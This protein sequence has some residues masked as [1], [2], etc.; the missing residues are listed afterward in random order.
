[1]NLIIT[2]AN[3]FIG[4]KYLSLYGTKFTN[5]YVIGRHFD[6]RIKVISNVTFLD[7]NLAKPLVLDITHKIDVFIHLAYDGT[8]LENNIIAIRNILDFIKKQA[9]ER[10]IF[11]SSYSVYDTTYE[12]FL[13]ENAPYSKINDPYSVV[14][15]NCEKIIC[16]FSE[17]IANINCIVL[18]PSN[19]YGLMGNWSMHAVKSISTSKLI[20]PKEG[21]CNPVYVDD[22]CQAIHSSL[23]FDLPKL[24]FQKFLISSEESCEWEKFYRS[25]SIYLSSFQKGEIEFTEDISN[26]EFNTSVPKNIIYHLLFTKIGFLLLKKL[27]PLIRKNKSIRIISTDLKKSYIE[28]KKLPPFKPSGMNRVAHR[29]KFKVDISKAKK[30]L[31]YSPKF[32]LSNLGDGFNTKKND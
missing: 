22:V 14:K 3:G 9:I 31:S 7:W 27:M 18:Q 17:S 28:W 29:L 20:L 4:Y 16:R 8:I 12:G 25:H 6:D 32:L 13:T 26:L 1:M 5:I 23:I 21:I 30:I 10:F 2:G 11:M 19:V 24:N 15:I